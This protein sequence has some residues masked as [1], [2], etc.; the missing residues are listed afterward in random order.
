MKQN[1][2]LASLT[3]VMCF[4][5][6]FSIKYTPIKRAEQ[7]KEKLKAFFSFYCKRSSYF[8]CNV[9]ICGGSKLDACT[10]L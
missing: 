1:I 10:F 6:M 3:L 2:L 5:A 9:L 4:I 7:M 8:Y